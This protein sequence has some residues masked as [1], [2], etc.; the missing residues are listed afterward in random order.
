MHEDKIRMDATE[1][2]VLLE[3]MRALLEQTELA[4]VR[5]AACAAENSSGGGG[6]VD[7]QMITERFQHLH[8]KMTSAMENAA[9]IGA[10]YAKGEAA[11]AEM[12]DSLRLP[13]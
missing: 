1:M 11:V 7:L 5:A 9:E 12:V 6:T 13:F 4:F 2:S 3:Q 10:L 8:E